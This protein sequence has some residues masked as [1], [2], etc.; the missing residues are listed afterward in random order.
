MQDGRL[1]VAFGLEETLRP[2]ETMIGM[3]M[4]RADGRR[5]VRTNALSVIGLAVIF[6]R[7]VVS[8]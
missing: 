3:P 1:A 5:V 2:G 7:T 6:L 4:E 8:H